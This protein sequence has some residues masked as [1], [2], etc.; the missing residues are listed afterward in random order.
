LGA[1]E[2]WLLFG[3]ALAAFLAA[4]QAERQT[5]L[6]LDLALIGLALLWADTGERTGSSGCPSRSTLRRLDVLAADQSDLSRGS[7]NITSGPSNSG[8]YFNHDGRE[9]AR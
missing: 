6:I 4:N 3:A 7:Q 5:A 1:V 9:Y 2:W 8:R